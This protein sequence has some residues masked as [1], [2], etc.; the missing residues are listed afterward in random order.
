MLILIIP[1]QIDHSWTGTTTCHKKELF[2]IHL[3][4]RVR[5]IFSKMSTVNAKWPLS[6]FSP[7]FVLLTY[8]LIIMC[9]NVFPWIHIVRKDEL[10]LGLELLKQ[11]V[12]TIYA[13]LFN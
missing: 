4:L 8:I 6:L 11:E 3:I 7:V 5:D 1:D 2:V 10:S 13:H 9:N 12:Q